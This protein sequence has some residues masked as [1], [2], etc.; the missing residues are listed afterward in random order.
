M[1]GLPICLG[2]YRIPSSL[3]LPKLLNSSYL[4]REPAPST[5]PTHLISPCCRLHKLLAAQQFLNLRLI[6]AQ[7]EKVVAL[8][9]S[10]GGGT[11]AVYEVIA[12]HIS[13]PRS[14]P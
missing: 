8:K 10:V 1:H 9:G 5:P 11:T 2:E 6:P 14:N 7:T 4:G 12:V 3:Q 13:A